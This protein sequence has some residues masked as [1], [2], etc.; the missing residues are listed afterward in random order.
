MNQNQKRSLFWIVSGIAVLLL[1]TAVQYNAATRNRKRQE[2]REHATVKNVYIITASGL[3]PDHLSSYLYQHIQ[4][5][6]IDFLAGDGV[7]FTHAFT[8]SPESLAAHLSLLTGSYPFHKPVKQAIDSLYELAPGTPPPDTLGSLPEFFRKNSYKTVAF[9]SDPGL[10]FAMYFEKLF[11][12]VY[13]G[14]RQVPFWQDSYSPAEVCKLARDWVLEHQSEP[15]FMLLNFDDPARPFDPPSPY[16]KHYENHPY[17]GEIAALDEQIGLFINLLKISGLFDKSIVILTSPYGENFEGKSHAGLMEDQVL[18]VPLIITAPGLLPNHQVYDSQVSLVDVFPTLFRLLEKEPAPPSDGVPL[19]QKG[20]TEQRGH[21]VILGESRFARLFRFPS[22]YYVRS[23][24]WKLVHGTPDEMY[25]NYP[26]DTASDS[27]EAKQTMEQFKKM[28]QNN[29][30]DMA[31]AKLPEIDFDPSDL[32]DSAVEMARKGNSLFAADILQSFLEHQSPT[33]YISNLLGQLLIESGNPQEAVAFYRKSFS[34]SKNPVVVPYIARAQ[35]KA[36]QYADASRTLESIR[37]LSYYEYSSLGIAQLN[38]NKTKDAILSF[39]RALLLNPLYSQ[40]YLYRGMA[41]VASQDRE[42]AG[43]DFRKAIQLYPE[44]PSPYREI[45]TLFVGKEDSIPYL[46]K[47]LEIDPEDYVTMLA[48]A[49]ME[50]KTGNLTEAKSL[51]E[52]IL[53][54]SNQPDLKNSAKEIIAQ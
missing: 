33:P 35:L 50:A 19:F 36:L 28:L 31:A 54:Y 41:Y 2:E 39:N 9:L 45:A 15:H 25:N 53:L 12:E 1:I 49:S 22:I 13:A 44:D 17:D 18:N 32:L 38:S 11:D 43:A 30:V 48:L 5:P 52:K 34:G 24:K 42:R 47:L 40:A 21:D 46:R 8:A 4:T 51:S 10:R 27:L 23:S 7:R 37:N 14:N 6:A 20:S 26:P 16:N 29:G 3:R